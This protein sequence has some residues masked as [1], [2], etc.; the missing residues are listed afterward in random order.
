[1]KSFEPPPKL[2]STPLLRSAPLPIPVLI[3]LITFVAV[4]YRIRQINEHMGRLVTHTKAERSPAVNIWHEPSVSSFKH[5]QPLPLSENAQVSPSSSPVPP[6]RQLRAKHRLK[7][8]TLHWMPQLF[9]S[10]SASPAVGPIKNS[11]HNPTNPP[12][13][14]A[15]LRWNEERH[16]ATSSA[17]R[18]PSQLSRQQTID[19]T[20]GPSGE[21][22]I[23][24]EEEEDVQASSVATTSALSETDDE[25]KPELTLDTR[26]PEKASGQNG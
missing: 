12:P 14:N 25:G 9:R 17:T 21:T 23:D 2:K 15:A 18:K 20:D 1:M 5:D 8:L 6:T 7:G 11:A 19:D 22:G 3:E 24:E 10:T 4:D 16:S 13:R 26:R